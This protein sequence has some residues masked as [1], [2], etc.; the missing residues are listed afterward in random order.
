[1]FLV[2][3]CVCSSSL[4]QVLFFITINGNTLNNLVDAPINVTRFN[5]LSSA[6]YQAVDVPDNGTVSV[7]SC[8]KV[9]V[10]GVISQLDWDSL[11]LALSAAYSGSGNYTITICIS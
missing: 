5:A 11:S 9:Y 8:L 6:Q 7:D 1:M 3:F 2:L 4:W 10:T